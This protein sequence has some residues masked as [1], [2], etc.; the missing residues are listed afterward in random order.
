MHMTKAPRVL[1]LAAAAATV[2]LGVPQV[3][4]RVLAQP[5][6][7]R[8]A[9][10]ASGHSNAG[11]L[12]ALKWIREAIAEAKAQHASSTIT[13]KITVGN[14]SQCPPLPAGD[15]PA[16]T[17]CVLIHI[18]GGTLDLGNS[19]QVINRNIN[20]SFG[21]GTD[22][23]GNPFLIRGTLRSSPMPVLGG[24]FLESLVEKIVQ[25]DPNLQLAVKPVGV[26]QALD[27][28]GNTAL[29]VSQKIKAINPVFG[30]TC[31]IGSTQTPIVI[32]PTFGTT[33]P[34]APNQPESGHI[35][36][37]E[38]LNNEL[39]IIGTVVDNAFAAPGSGGCGPS[40]SLDNVVNAVS[41]LPSPAG[42]NNAVFQVAVEL[43]PYSFL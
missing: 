14:F 4:A 36:S 19:H 34:P 12:A 31:F 15:D 35:D 2:M 38:L 20:I 16:S 43:T 9:A 17:F 39:I 37:A 30:T 6:S 28:T 27:P 3:S 29:I 8:S 25:T 40:D 13:P 7:P 24:I 41:G 10:A 5:D 18:T 21:E 32:D 22:A 26:G 42:T 23:N 1:A 33:D 11:P